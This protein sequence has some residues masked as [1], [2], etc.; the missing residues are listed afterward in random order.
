MAVSPP[1]ASRHAVPRSET[2]KP[3]SEASSMP[4]EA[5][6][7]LVSGGQA[8]GSGELV[9]N[10][11]EAAQDLLGSYLIST[12]GG[13]VTG[14]R[15]VETEAYMGRQD[16]ASHAAE[17]IGRTAR[18]A[19]MFGESG[20]AYVYF[21]YG[22]HWCVN[23]VTG[24]EG[25]PQAVLV[26]AIEPQFGTA[27]MR[28]RRG[29]DRDLTNGPARLCQALGIDGRLNGHPLGKAPLSLIAGK[30]PSGMK[31]GVSGRVGVRMADDWPL[32]FFLEG[33]AAVS[34]SKACKPAPRS[35]LP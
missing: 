10:A 29:R 18:N 34:R 24:R 4:P 7:S 30:R 20:R 26:R 35:V 15:I 13:R 9:T 2:L 27:P 19:T 28:Q 33:H 3:M 21:V 25:D 1:T 11:E 8:I 5:W 14:G 31:I 16:P 12:V 23:V 32:R 17:R 22:M 6:S